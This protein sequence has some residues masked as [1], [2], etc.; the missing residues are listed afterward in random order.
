ME[1]KVK[2]SKV[3]KVKRDLRAL[4]SSSHAIE[5]LI[6]AQG[7]HFVR[8]KAL[9]ALPKS[10][11]IQTIIKK[12][13]E[14]IRCLGLAEVIEKSEEMERRYM[15]ALSKLELNDRAI[16]TDYYIKGAPCFQV[17]MD[18]G[19]SEGGLRKKLDRLISK[20]AESV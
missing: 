10:E 5:R 11:K 4:R 9:E 14:I 12:E 2:L 3:N 15:G 13:N 18:Y 6:E 7:I 8:I 20:I 16:I 1:N 17:A 19:F